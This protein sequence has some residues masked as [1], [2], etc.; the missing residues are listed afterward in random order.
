MPDSQALLPLDIDL[1]QA[2][3]T[4]KPV[5]IFRFLL[6]SLSG[7]KRSALVL[8]LETKGGGPRKPGAVMGVNADG[9]YCGFI[10]G[11]CVEA[12]VAREALAAIKAGQDRLCVFGKGS[13]W[14]DIVLPCGGSVHLAIHVLR[15][16]PPG[17]THPLARLL[18]GLSNRRAAGL[19][20]DPEREALLVNP[21]PGGQTGWQKGVFHAFYRPDPLVILAG[22][23]VEAQAFKA[24][25]VAAGLDV[26]S[27][28]DHN[29]LPLP[30][31]ETAFVLLHHDIDREL[32]VL[33]AALASQA[34]YIGCLG[35]KRTRTRRVEL[36]ERESVSPEQLARIH[37]PIGLFGPTRDARS[38]AVSVLAEILS[39]A[40]DDDVTG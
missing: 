37:A 26:T 39:L 38:L 23:G 9:E 33:R 7:E 16:E 4:D 40:S 31:R 20:Y 10:S 30:D 3:I 12:N 2:G 15:D 13:P 5:D 28:Q 18:D 36:L 25:A 27:V 35:S 11:G 24:I 1:K 14:F 8:L 34:F 21:D 32:P 22:D 17:E 19:V 6:N 29:Q